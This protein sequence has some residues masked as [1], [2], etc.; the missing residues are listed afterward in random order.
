MELKL[1]RTKTIEHNNFTTQSEEY[2]LVKWKGGA[3]RTHSPEEQRLPEER[4]SNCA[5]LYEYYLRTV[6]ADA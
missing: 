4:R 2:N 1:L 3:I 5:N 6:H